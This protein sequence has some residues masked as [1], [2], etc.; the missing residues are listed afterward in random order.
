[1]VLVTKVEESR[2]WVAAKAAACDFCRGFGDRAE[3]HQCV[4]SRDSDHLLSGGFSRH[5][6]GYKNDKS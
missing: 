2:T 1:M 3:E 5:C 6:V 4:H